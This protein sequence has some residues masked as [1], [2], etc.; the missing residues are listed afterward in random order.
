MTRLRPVIDRLMEKVTIDENGCWIF[1]GARSAAGYG[2][3]GAG[4]RDEG[5]V[6]VHRVTYEHRIGPIE[7]GYQV[8]HLCRVRACCNPKHLEAVTQAENIRRALVLRPIKTHCKRDHEFTDDNTGR[9]SRGGRY[10][11]TCVGIRRSAA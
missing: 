10:C 3:I 7:P 1:T 6:Y 2:V 11:R 5:V 9:N 4:G 8:D